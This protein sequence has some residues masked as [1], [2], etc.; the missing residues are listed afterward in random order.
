MKFL[1]GLMI[2]TYLKDSTLAGSSFINLM[3]LFLVNR[4]I[5]REYLPQAFSLAMIS[6]LTIPYRVFEKVKFVR[7]I[8]ELEIDLPPIFII[9]HHRSGTTYFHDLMS[10][11]PNFGY[12]EHWQ[13]M[14]GSEIFL[15][16]PE[17]AKDWADSNYPRKRRADDVMVLASS[18]A[19]EEFALGNSSPYSFYTWLWFPKNM[20]K[21]FQQCVLFEYEN[22]QI[23]TQW[24]KAYTT[25]LKRIILS[26]NG[27]RLLLKNPVNTARINILLEIFPD[28]K[29]IYLYRNPYT[30][31]ASASQLYKRILPLSRLQNITEVELEEN[32]IF[33][34]QQIMQK[35]LVDKNHIPPENLIEVKY[36]D[37]IGNEI[38]YLNKIYTQFKL[39]GFEHSES[40]FK[41]YIDSQAKY[42]TNKYILDEKTI[43]KITEEWR[44][45]IEKWQYDIPDEF[46]ADP[47]NGR[48]LE[49][50]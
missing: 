31:Y 7:K 33:I 44:F 40:E 37:F 15:S 27:K 30:V 12:L 23:K 32:I 5:D 45:T 36:E 47:E 2:R 42:K 18:P 34:Y 22:E 43:T 25:I 26:K 24:K 29:F 17:L 41:K 4:G 14:R 38:L 49:S 20:K 8:A 1:T 48:S 35:Y 46:R 10:R 9:G 28:A 39:S 3:K 50:I 11:D 6:F 19:E 21:I 13:G 16:S